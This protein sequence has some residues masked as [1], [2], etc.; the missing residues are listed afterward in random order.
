MFLEAFVRAWRKNKSRF[1]ISA[2][3]AKTGLHFDHP[4]CSSELKVLQHEGGALCAGI[5]RKGAQR[6][7]V[8]LSLRF[9]VLDKA[10]PPY[11]AGTWTEQLWEPGRVFPLTVQRIG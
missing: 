7:N 5:G 1:S 8:L 9:L 4:Y 3:H 10:V 11:A 6:T 2:F